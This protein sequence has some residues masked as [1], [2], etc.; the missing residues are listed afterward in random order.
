MPPSSALKDGY[1]S[2]TSLIL[3]RVDS[4]GRS[5]GAQTPVEAKADYNR[6]QRGGEVPLLGL[7]MSAPEKQKGRPKWKKSALKMRKVAEELL[8]TVRKMINI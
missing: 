2:D 7:R 4:S 1:E 6:I 3:R 8:P 5:T